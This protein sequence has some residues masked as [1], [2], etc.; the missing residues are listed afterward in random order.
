[1][2]HRKLSWL[3][4]SSFFPPSKCLGRNVQKIITFDASKLYSFFH[5]VIEPKFSSWN[6]ETEEHAFGLLQN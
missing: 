6:I 3:G 1:M 2:L 4:T 5:Q